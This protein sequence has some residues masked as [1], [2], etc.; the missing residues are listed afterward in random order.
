MRHHRHW[1]PVMEHIAGCELSC[2]SFTLPP[3]GTV[4]GGS[5]SLQGGNLTLACFHGIN[6]RA[7]SWA[8]F[9]M[10]DPVICFTTEA[11][12]GIENSELPFCNFEIKN[13]FNCVKKCF[14]YVVTIIIL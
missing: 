9:S 11:V 14:S 1:Q 8:L 7:K 13:F 3:R 2:L 5:V 12:Q 10:D 6:F 4:L